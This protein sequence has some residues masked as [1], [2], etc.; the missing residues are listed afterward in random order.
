M[1]EPFAFERAS[2]VGRA[3]M[4]CDS[5]FRVGGLAADVNAQTPLL[6]NF[7]R[8]VSLWNWNATTNL[9]NH[10]MLADLAEKERPTVVIEQWT[11]RYL[12]T[13]PPDHPEFQRARAAA[14]GN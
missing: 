2:G 8:F 5:F 4:L 3:V 10:E 12:R 1:S 11:E 14:G 6:L 9:A 13:P 7:Q